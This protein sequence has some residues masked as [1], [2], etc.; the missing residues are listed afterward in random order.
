M[1]RDWVHLSQQ[2]INWSVLMFLFDES[3]LIYSCSVY[4]ECFVLTRQNL[5]SSFDQF[6]LDL[7]YSTGKRQINKSLFPNKNKSVLRC[8]LLL[9]YVN[10]WRHIPLQIE[11]LKVNMFLYDGIY[12]SVVN[13][14]GVWRRVVKLFTF[15]AKV[16][17]YT[18]LMCSEN[19]SAYMYYSY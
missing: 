9:C 1:R 19:L 11:N 14:G 3:N 7:V 16:S 10:L 15:I 18:L 2:P 12:R 8:M 13:C 4:G 5:T 6:Q 17:F